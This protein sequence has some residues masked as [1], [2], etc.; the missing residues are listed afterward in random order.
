MKKMKF[1]LLATISVILISCANENTLDS[2]INQMIKNNDLDRAQNVIE[3][4]LNDTSSGENLGLKSRQVAEFL[5]QNGKAAEAILLLNN[6]LKNHFETSGTKENGE[7]L[8]KIFEENLNKPKLADL[9]RQSLSDKEGQKSV[10]DELRDLGRAIFSETGGGFNRS[11]AQDFVYGA[12]NFALLNPKDSLSPVF[13]ID[14]ATI[15]RNLGNTTETLELFKWVYE[16]FPNHKKAPE[17]MFYEAFTYD[18]D[19]KDYEKARTAYETFMEKNPDHPF[20]DQA[21]IMMDNLGKSDEELL[22]NLS[23]TKN[24]D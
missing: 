10:P 18:S 11:I 3:K 16:K 20:V 4:L 23:K 17:A 1:F 19:L 12:E 9:I 15:A 22:E 13:L 14:A 2:E 6:C 8:A 24:Q 5:R 21:K 7:M